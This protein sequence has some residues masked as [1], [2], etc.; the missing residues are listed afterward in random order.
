MLTTR[1]QINCLS[2]LV[3]QHAMSPKSSICEEL[4]RAKHLSDDTVEAERPLWGHERKL[5]LDRCFSALVPKAD[6]RSARLWHTHRDRTFLI[7]AMPALWP[8]IASRRWR[9]WSTAGA[10]RLSI[11]RQHEQDMAAKR[12]LRLA[13]VEE[14]MRDARVLGEQRRKVVGYLFCNRRV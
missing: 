7:T 8:P 12:R 14:H 2:Y 13:A 11:F 3:G 6:L 5:I 10:R 9:R 4:D 1:P